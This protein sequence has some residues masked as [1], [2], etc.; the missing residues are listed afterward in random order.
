MSDQLEINLGI[1]LAQNLR[2]LRS[3]RGIT[4]ARLAKQAAIP[5]STIAS[6]ETGSGNPTLSVLARLSLSLQVSI[7]ELLSTPRAQ[8]QLF[9]KGNLKSISRSGGA[10]SVAK[11][12]PEPVPG[13]E[14]DRIELK[15]GARLSGV[16][17]RPG[18]REY[19]C[20]ERGQLTLWAAGERLD[21]SP[22]DVAAF[23]GDQRH[24]YLNEG[25]TLA[26]GFSVVAIVPISSSRA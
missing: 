23:Q 18:T 14:I 11:L 22:G 7:E 20:C 21:L 3:Q 17:H 13:M 4:Q 25:D 26:I 19:L 12:L 6:L 9:K 8:S 2:Y 16:P 1:N 10:V 5:R 24:S 15:P